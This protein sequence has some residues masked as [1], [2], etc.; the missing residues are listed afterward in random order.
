[1]APEM[2]GSFQY[3]TAADI[4]GL[5]VA[6]HEMVTSTPPYSD[7]ELEGL[8]ERYKN[9]WR[10]AFQ[11]H[12]DRR[13]QRSQLLWCIA[14]HGEVPSLAQIKNARFAHIGE[15][16]NRRYDRAPK[17]LIL[18]NITESDSSQ[19]LAKHSAVVGRDSA[20]T[21]LSHLFLFGGFAGVLA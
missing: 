18:R 19:L 16:S 5:G 13:L 6:M 9:K 15:D 2:V 20:A 1:M 8:A 21:K 12:T 17:P 4:Y 3:S 14:E 7:E 11:H 10:S